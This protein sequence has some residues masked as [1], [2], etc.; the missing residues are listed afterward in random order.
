GSGPPRRGG[1]PTS[2]HRADPCNNYPPRR[3]AAGVAM[4]GTLRECPGRRPRVR[5]RH[6]HLVR[7]RAAVA[8]GG[9]VSVARGLTLEGPRTRASG[10]PPRR[11]R[12]RPA[13]PDPDRSDD[14]APPPRP[15]PTPPP[16][17]PPTPTP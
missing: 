15:P 10:G 5:G 12:P 1:R 9:A 17:P 14:S 7:L 4:D 2:R 6:P 11:G 8:A 13:D 3:P 16:S